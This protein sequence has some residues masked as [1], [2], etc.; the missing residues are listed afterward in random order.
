MSAPKTLSKGVTEAQFA[1]F[2]EARKKAGLT[3][4]QAK[5]KAFR[6]FCESQGVAWP[7]TAQHG[8]A[9]Q[10]KRP[11]YHCPKCDSLRTTFVG[12]VPMEGFVA[13]DPDAVDD[14]LFRC[15]DCG[16][17]FRDRTADMEYVDTDEAARP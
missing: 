1:A 7:G 3:T 17:E 16:N 2:E 8:G 6:M 14:M 12:D 9:R 5:D 15:L 13:D 10:H 11:R 4:N